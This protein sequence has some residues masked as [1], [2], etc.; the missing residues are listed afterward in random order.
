MQWTLQRQ[1]RVNDSSGGNGRVNSVIYCNANHCVM[2]F[3]F[4]ILRR[5]LERTRPFFEAQSLCELSK[6]DKFID[7]PTSLW[8][9][10]RR[11]GCQLW[12]LWT[13]DTNL[14]C[15]V[16]LETFGK[17]QGSI[18]GVHRQQTE[19]SRS[20]WDECVNDGCQKHC[21]QVRVLGLLAEKQLQAVQ[22]HPA[23]DQVTLHCAADS[24]HPMIHLNPIVHTIDLGTHH[25]DLQNKELQII[26]K[27]GF[28]FR[29][30]K[31]WILF[32][33]YC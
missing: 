1:R 32:A 26:A 6:G 18:C 8:T 3:P 28:S 22:I 10:P 15:H 24:E 12:S 9:N 11:L 31:M 20:S 21:V 16:G 19:Q 13:V 23:L 7:F 5:L 14:F 25:T 2:P 33:K 4:F 27:V 17:A 29:L 30:R